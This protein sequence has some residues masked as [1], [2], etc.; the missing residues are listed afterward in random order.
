METRGNK[1]H[2]PRTERVSVLTS[3]EANRS[4]HARS[5]IPMPAPASKPA[6]TSRGIIPRFTT[7]MHPSN[8]KAISRQDVPRT[9]RESARIRSDP[10]R[11]FERVLAIRGAARVTAIAK[12]AGTLYQRRMSAVS[13]SLLPS[14]GRNALPQSR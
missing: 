11:P 5:V 3:I 2:D 7:N 8:T 14:S 10:P 13:K 12:R 9:D 1:T 4:C 6:A